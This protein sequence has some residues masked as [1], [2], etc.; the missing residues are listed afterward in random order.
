MRLARAI[1]ALAAA[2]LACGGGDDG[3]P[4]GGG[5]A[6]FG[7]LRAEVFPNCT[8]C[9][10]SLA[11]G[12]AFGSLDLLSGGAPAIHARLVGVAAAWPNAN[13]P[14]RVVAGDPD[15][16]LLYRKL[17]IPNPPGGED[18]SLGSGMPQDRP[19]ALPQAQ[20]DLVRDW[21]A[22]GAPND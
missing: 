19:G 16:S 2:L 1:P 22:R 7:R 8:G 12:G 20:K 13:P 10:N 3:G 5:A 15:A 9:H 11:T 14:L 21:I 6:T 4:P 18:P 17:L